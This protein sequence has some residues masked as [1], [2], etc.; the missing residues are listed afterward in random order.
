MLIVPFFRLVSSEGHC[1]ACL[2]TLQ[3]NS[4]TVAADI[5]LRSIRATFTVDVY[6]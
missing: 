1:R 5:E 3:I 2:P 4:A 6:G